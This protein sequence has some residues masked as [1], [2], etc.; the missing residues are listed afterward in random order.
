VSQR[1]PRDHRVPRFLR[2]HPTKKSV[3]SSPPIRCG[4]RIG[5][6]AQFGAFREGEAK[7]QCSGQPVRSQTT[8][9]V[10]HRILEGPRSAQRFGS[11]SFA[12]A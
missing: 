7:D 9:L 2:P 1:K 4:L 8:E 11:G 3:E 6:G 5:C 10:G 12:F